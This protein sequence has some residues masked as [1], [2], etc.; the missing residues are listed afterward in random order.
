MASESTFASNT[1]LDT[2]TTAATEYTAQS[3]YNASGVLYWRIQAEDEN[4][5]D[6]TWSEARSF[7]IDLDQPTL[8]PATPTL[9]DAS[10]P[11]L[12]WFPVPGAVSYT[13]RIHSPNDSTPDVFSGFPSTAASFEKITGTGL[14]T[15]EIRADF[16]RRTAAPLRARGRT[17]RITRTRSRSPPIRCRAR[18][19]TGSS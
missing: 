3:T 18:A 19:R 16:R 2:V 1:V 4:D 5:N 10:L 15:W 7:E 8:D 13:L 17:T 14:F 12:R 11:V 9:G 6:L